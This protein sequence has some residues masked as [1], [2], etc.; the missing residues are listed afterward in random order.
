MLVYFNG[1]FMPKEDVCLS[2]DDRGFLFADGVY[3]VFRSYKGRLFRAE[4][5]LARM[6]R[7]LRELRVAGPDAE[8]LGDIAGQLIQVNDLAD[9]DAAVYIQVTRGAAPRRH[10]FPGPDVPPTVYAFAY[11]I[12]RS[13]ERWDNGVK[14]ILVPDIRWTR[15]DIKSIALLPSVLASQR[16]QEAGADE[17][18]FV[19]DGAITEGAHTNFCAVFDGQVV[20]YPRTHYILPGI[21]RQV[22]SELCRDLGIPFREYPVLESRLR[23]AGE[24]MILGTITEIVPVVQVDDWPVGDGKPG[25]VTQSLQRAFCEMIQS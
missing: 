3:E 6:V 22:V 12:Q 7:S 13:Q 17:A 2:P 8:T 21:T 11:P 18:V 16:A 23:Q 14:V 20:T 1:R 4:S 5:H 19:R 9:G 25:P 24:L 15:C 10:A